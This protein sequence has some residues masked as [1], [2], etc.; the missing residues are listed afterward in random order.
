MSVEKML[1]ATGNVEAPPEAVFSL[2]SDPARHTS[3]DG[4]DMLRGLDS[5]PSPVTGVGD[6]FVMNMEQDGI[7]TYQMRSEVTTFE[8]DRAIAWAPAIHPEGS[9]KDV[10]GD[11]DPRGHVYDWVLEPGPEG[12]TV[13]THTYDWTAIS[14]PDTLALYPRVSQEQLQ[15]SI[16]NIA[17]TL[18]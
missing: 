6:A 11:L 16:A 15:G 13:V 3:F 4:A 17:E 5:G 9:L 10:I 18:R 14:D 7:G 2:L 12:G 8:P 1:S